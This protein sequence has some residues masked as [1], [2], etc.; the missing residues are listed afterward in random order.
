MS[1]PVPTPPPPTP[2]PQPPGPAAIP[3]VNDKGEFAENW[4]DR[5]PEGLREAPALKNFKSLEGLT[6]SLL[7]AQKMVGADKLVMPNDSS[8]D[9]EKAEF[10]SK[11]GRPDTPEGYE[12]KKIDPNSLPKGLDANPEFEKAFA[13]KAFE[14]GLSKDQAN[15][16]RDWHQELV[17]G[18]HRDVDAETQEEF[19][20]SSSALKKEWGMAYQA[21]VD[22]A[23]KVLI[24]FDPQLTLVDMGLGNNPSLIKMFAAIG[25]SM[26]EDSFIAG[27]AEKTPGNAQSEINAILGD[28]KNPYFVKDHPQHNDMV[29]KV[30]RYFE[31]KHAGKI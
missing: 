15:Q 28:P 21:N 1:D 3:F 23:N 17:M 7:S 18:S 26:S 4:F 10:F 14:L 5:L 11:I 27:E 30:A 29:A 16:L 19:E 8:S 12:F 13:N 2:P 24:K 31:Q 25:K 20:K 9:E 22:L 6:K